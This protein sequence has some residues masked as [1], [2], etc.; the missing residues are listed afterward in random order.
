MRSVAA[1][2]GGSVAKIPQ[3]GGC[4]SNIY[5]RAVGQ[6]Q[7][8]AAQAA[9]TAEEIGKWLRFYIYRFLDGIAAAVQVGDNQGYGEKSRGGIDMRRVF[10]GAEVQGP[11]GRI[12]KIPDPAGDLPAQV[13]VGI[14]Q[15]SSH[16]VLAAAP[17][18]E[19]GHRTVAYAYH[20]LV[21]G[22]TSLA[23]V[24]RKGY[25]VISL[26]RILMGYIRAVGEIDGIGR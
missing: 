4:G 26:C 16:L 19:T 6:K 11:G 13:F 9:G 25:I 8:G 2:S 10:Q 21:F 15:E 17:G 14:I 22:R 18:C 7:R 1:E 20:R 24:H 12:T 3:V 23:V 5:Q